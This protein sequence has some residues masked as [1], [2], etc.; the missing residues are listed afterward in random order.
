MGLGV[1]LPWDQVPSLLDTWFG[2]GKHLG[3]AAAS[4]RYVTRTSQSKQSSAEN[5]AHPGV[6]CC[7]SMCI[8]ATNPWVQVP[9]SPNVCFGHWWGQEPSGTHSVS[10]ITSSWGADAAGAPPQQYS[11]AASELLQLQCFT[12]AALARLCH[13]WR[14]CCKQPVLVAFMWPEELFTDKKDKGHSLVKAALR[15]HYSSGCIKTLEA[16]Y[17]YHTCMQAS[18]DPSGMQS[19]S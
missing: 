6:Y 13:M 3:I 10:P 16:G 19:L 18:P 11:A 12:A 7:H 17:W 5:R 2:W 8:N 4:L 1:T 15:L 9:S 14:Q